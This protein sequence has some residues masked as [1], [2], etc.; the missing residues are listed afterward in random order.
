V[1][2]KLHP[3]EFLDQCVADVRAGRQSL[4]ECVARGSDQGDDLGEL[5]SAALAITPLDVSPNP[6]AKVHARYLLVEAMHAQSVARPGPWGW[7]AALGPLRLQAAAAATALILAIG[8]GGAAVV[9]AQESQPDD[10]LY[11]LKTAIEQQ[12]VAM[13]RSPEERALTRVAIASRR[14]KE[15]ERALSDG[16]PEV[17]VVA[18]TAYSETVERAVQEI[19][20]AQDAGR[21]VEDAIHDLERNEAW[22]RALTV[23]AAQRDANAARVAL[24]STKERGGRRPPVDPTSPTRSA[25]AGSS[26]GTD[27]V[28]VTPTAVVPQALGTRPQSIPS[29]AAVEIAYELDEEEPGEEEV[30][31]DDDAPGGNAHEQLVAQQDPPADSRPG[32]AGPS[33]QRD[34]DAGRRN[35]GRDD[36][37]DRAVSVSSA[38]ALPAVQIPRATPIPTPTRV[39]PPPPPLIV[40]ASSPTAS[41][42]RSDDD[43]DDDRDAPSPTVVPTPFGQPN[44]AD[45]G[46]RSNDDDDRDDRDDDRESDDSSR[47]GRWSPPVLIRTP[48]PTVAAART[49]TR[50][51]ASVD[52]DRRGQRDDDAEESSRA[53]RLPSGSTSQ[54]QDRRDRDDDDGPDANRGVR[55]SATPTRTPTPTATPTPIAR[56]SEADTIKAEQPG[57]SNA[58]T[59]PDTRPAPQG[60][61]R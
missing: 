59:A 27:A 19:D 18:A 50:P 49:P 31:D 20:Q 40:V 16:K 36:D 33:A 32:V 23:T 30:I 37:G 8:S 55:P 2:E 34:D 5:L 26:G 1:T 22:Q 47:T 12:Q 44:I 35:D 6:L 3:M 46:R 4:D 52:Q 21:P 45:G 58:S 54:E 43:N 51:A 15:V 10:A 57:K 11:G 7:L 39:S 29:A 41:R 60:S 17:A 42:G 28:D 61:R 53:G 14:L 13:A 24:E 9:A 38:T 56:R 48:V 25:P